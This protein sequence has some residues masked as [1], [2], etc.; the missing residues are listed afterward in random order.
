[1]RQTKPMNKT[2]RPNDL[3]NGAF[4]INVQK[5]TIHPSRLQ[6]EAKKFPYKQEFKVEEER[7]K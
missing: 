2:L 6:Y 4:A 7:R 1:M 3:K 5:K